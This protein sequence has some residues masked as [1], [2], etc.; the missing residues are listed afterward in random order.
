M[1][2]WP[3]GK[4]PPE[5]AG[6]TLSTNSPRQLS[7]EERVAMDEQARAAR[8]ASRAAWV[9]AVAACV[10]ALSAVAAALIAY[11]ATELW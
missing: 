2:H 6:N 5:D 11:Q 10:A 3:S 7:H 8:S 4:L 9:A 1:A